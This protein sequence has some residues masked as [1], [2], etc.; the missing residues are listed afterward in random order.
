MEQENVKRFYSKVV[1]YIESSLAE[2]KWGLGDALPSGDAIARELQMSPEAA[3]D[4][5]RTLEALDVV[6]TGDNSEARLTGRF[7]K[8][9]ADSFALALLVDAIDFLEIA[10]LRRT[11]ETEAFTL[12]F[13]LFNDESL[14]ALEAALIRLEN[15]EANDSERIDLDAAFHNEIIRSG[16]NKLLVMLTEGLLSVYSMQI[17]GEISKYSLDDRMKLRKAH[18]D[19]YTALRDGDFQL[20]LDAIDAHYK[21]IESY[22]VGFKRD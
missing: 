10:R 22:L 4:V 1:E 17:K 21:I 7:S 15:S 3:R 2:K 13:S 18:R 9:F 8:M 14:Q 20:G 5:L 11:L 6:E 12:A 16:Q 19:I